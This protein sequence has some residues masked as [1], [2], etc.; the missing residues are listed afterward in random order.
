M[1]SWLV[2]LY[3]VWSG[4]SCSFRQ[5]ALL[6]ISPTPFGGSIGRLQSNGSTRRLSEQIAMSTK[7]RLGHAMKMKHSIVMLGLILLGCRIA[8][9]LGATPVMVQDFEKVS[10]PPTVW[11][12]N[13]PNE[14]AS[15]QLST[16]Q[17]HE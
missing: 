1:L 16:D 14:N 13:V 7:S 5:D 4:K 11:V 9:T 2:P 10:T 12:V 3:P 17:P 15:V 6:A 8:P